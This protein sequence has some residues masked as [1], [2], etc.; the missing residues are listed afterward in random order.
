MLVDS[1][2]YGLP[3]SSPLLRSQASPGFT[4]MTPRTE[5]YKVAEIIEPLILS[6]GGGLDA[7]GHFAGEYKKVVRIDP[8][9]REQHGL[10]HD[11]CIAEGTPSMLREEQ[12]S[13]KAI[14]AAA[15]AEHENLRVPAFMP[16]ESLNDRYLMEFIPSLKFGRGSEPSVVKPQKFG[17]TEAEVKKV[18]GK[19]AEYE[20]QVN[21]IEDWV[22]QE[23]S[24]K[25]DLA[26]LQRNLRRLSNFIK[27]YYV[28]DL[29]ILIHESTF[30]I[31]L[32]DPMDF[33][34][35]NKL[36]QKNCKLSKREKRR[37]RSDKNYHESQKRGLA[38]LRQIISG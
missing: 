19:F 7:T 37:R 1:R 22:K 25:T 33:L 4:F 29:Q 35:A 36:Y 34:P 28:A 12:K 32:I 6:G 13:L 26:E 31:Y 16:F 21:D 20:K 14:G 38:K 2:D 10:F 11:W 24:K 9:T 8:S 18:N 15:R 23:K 17:L 3:F 27:K 30:Q 5:V